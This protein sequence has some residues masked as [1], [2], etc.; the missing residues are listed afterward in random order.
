MQTQTQTPTPINPALPWSQWENPVAESIILGEIEAVSQTNGLALS[1]HKN[2]PVPLSPRGLV[3]LGRKFQF[4]PDFLSGLAQDDPDL[5]ASV[6][7]RVMLRGKLSDDAQILYEGGQVVGLINGW[8]PM[9]SAQTLINSAYESVCERFDDD[10][11]EIKLSEYVNGQ[12]RA[13]FLFPKYGEVRP[14]RVGDVLRAG[15]EMLVKPGEEIDGGIY[16]ERLSCLNGATCAQTKFSWA[17][18]SEITG[19]SQI[20]WVKAF[21]AGVVEEFDQIVD[22]AREMAS[23]VVERPEFALRARMKALRV[24]KSH[25]DGI[26]AAF[27]EDEGNTEWDMINAITRYA[28]HNENLDTSTRSQL[29]SGAGDAIYTFD[30]CVAELPRQVARRVGATIL[31]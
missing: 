11:I 14:N 13:R 12:A 15:I 23:I 21:A 19:D 5:A 27:A 8:R 17:K 2:D 1:I 20:Q 7:N 16:T 4:P 28:T 9:V 26:L 22:K 10:S 31:Q 18:R 6:I 25:H 3:E 30:L 24:N 29:Q